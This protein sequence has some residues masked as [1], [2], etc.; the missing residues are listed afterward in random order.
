MNDASV[1]ALRE[2]K[3]EANSASFSAEREHVDRWCRR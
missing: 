2:V 1:C 3:A